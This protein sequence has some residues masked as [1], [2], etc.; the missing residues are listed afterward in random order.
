MTLGGGVNDMERVFEVDFGPKITSTLLR[1][2]DGLR[3][4]SRA[5]L[6]STVDKQ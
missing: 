2:F 5:H 1:F 6:P 3:D 4:T